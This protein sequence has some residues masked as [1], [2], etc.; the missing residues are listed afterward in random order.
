MTLLAHFLLWLAIGAGL[1]AATFVLIAEMYNRRLR[2]LA[3]QDRRR[4]RRAA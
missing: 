2:R 4:R 3:E 1:W